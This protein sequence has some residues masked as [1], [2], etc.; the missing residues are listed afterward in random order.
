MMKIKHILTLLTISVTAAL[1]FSSCEKAPPETP[2]STG[3]KSPPA[4]AEAP[5]TPGEIPNSASSPDHLVFEGSGA[6]G[7]GK[8][9]VL[10]SGDEEYRSEE[11]MPMLA[12]ILARQ[13]FKAT[14][15]FSLNEDGNVDPNAGENLSHPEA[16]D[17]ADALILGLRFRHWEGDAMDKFEAAFKR[18][19]PIIATRTSTHPF[20]FPGDSPWAHYS[21]K[22][23]AEGGWEK[24]FG[25]QVIGETWVS[26]H[27]KHKVE[28][29]RSYVEEANANHPILN[30]VGTIF[31]TEDVYGASPLEPATILLRGAVTETLEPD[32]A[33]VAD[34]NDPMQPVA[35]TRE[36]QHEDGTTNPIFT[37]TMGSATGFMDESLRR[38][39]LNGVFWG[40]GLDVPEKL[41]VTL[42]EGYLPSAFSFDE[43][44]LN[45]KPANFIP[46]DP[47]FKEAPFGVRPPN[48]P[49]APKDKA[50]K[51]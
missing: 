4:E 23:S 13:G 51:G 41:D 29:C 27:G 46:G 21:W 35:W 22:A 43:F 15:L 38:L 12:Q 39:V 6:S 24:G 3:T 16:L 40:L 33:E 28:G 9:I 37:T 31:V 1:T 49:K 14:V 17:T 18:G 48:K 34:K 25:R 30:G 20:N 50:K 10:L 42:P 26:H 44:R 2:E 7:N 45:L 32:S 47:A 36:Y 11:Y 19:T 5:A 8:H